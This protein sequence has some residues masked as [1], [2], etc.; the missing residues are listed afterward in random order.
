ML[1]ILFNLRCSNEILSK[2]TVA[3]MPVTL[4]ESD[5]GVFYV[6]EL[7]KNIFGDAKNT[8]LAYFSFVTLAQTESTL[9]MICV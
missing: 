1:K 3:E 6:T 2:K 7:E 4:T 5:L 8:Y 9:D